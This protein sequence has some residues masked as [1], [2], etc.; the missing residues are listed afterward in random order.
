MGLRGFIIK[1]VIN[2]FILLMFVLTINFVIFE[3]MPG[4]PIETLAASGRLRPGQTEEIFNLWGFNDPLP[5]R[6]GRYV[7]NML[8]WQFGYSFS[9]KASVAYELNGRLTN[10]LLLVGTSSILAIVIG[11]F[12]GVLAAYKRG[13][14][15]DSV[16]V[17][18]SLTTYALP[19]FWMGMMALLIFS[20]NL[21]WFPSAGSV[22]TDWARA[23][24]TPA[25][26]GVVLGTQISI[27]SLTE[28]SGRLYHLFL[29][30]AVLTLFSY[31]GYLLLT[32]AT[33]LETLSEDYVVTA[34]AKGLSE[35]TV[36]FRHALKNA[37]LPIITNVALTF[38]FLLTGAIITEQVFTYP[39]LG[40]WIWR[41]IGTADY[42]VMQAIF[43][44]IAL[45]VIIANFA[46]DLT[47]GLVDPRVK[48]G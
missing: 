19:S 7:V 8:Q 18:S 32:R 44:V 2:S 15:F 22:P 23:W 34:R 5:V 12:L 29:P 10:T 46:A 30:M 33:M 39:G 17:V 11:I 27:P 35:R 6:F 41:S 4:N 42:P 38:A 24:P 43:Y 16:S 48:Y 31:G 40:Q 9:S 28:I 3:L 26:Q 13:G 14:I 20:Y 1:R 36:L 47:Y 21:H 37:S 45:C 25:W